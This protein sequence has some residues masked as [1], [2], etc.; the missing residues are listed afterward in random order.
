MSEN[1]NNYS[2]MSGRIIGED[3]EVSNLV[4]LLKAI[5]LGGGSSM[6]FLYGSTVPTVDTGVN[7]DV[8][9]HTTNGDL[10][11]K[12]TGAWGKIA[13]LKGAN[14]TAGTA[15]VKGDTGAAGA[16]GDK[17]D[18]GTAG[19]AGAKGDKGDAGAKGADGFG[20][21]VEYDDIIARLVKL[22]PT[23]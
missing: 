8:Y 15:G 22:E 6:N 14:G 20:T 12:A 11:K 7:N 21:K 1:I 3:G 9:L 4:D 23:T 19:T 17:G 2:P 5:S 10:Y 13:N 16:K 18:T